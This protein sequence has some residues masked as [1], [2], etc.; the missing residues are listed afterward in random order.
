MVVFFV[1]DILKLFLYTR[2][3]VAVTRSLLFITISERFTLKFVS[4]P[5]PPLP[6][7]PLFFSSVLV[8]FRHPLTFDGG[9]N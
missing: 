4:R 9:P 7:P 3:F 5:P 1:N 8:S 6:P 2:L